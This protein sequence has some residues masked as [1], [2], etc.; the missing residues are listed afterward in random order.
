LLHPISQCDVERMTRNCI[1]ALVIGN[2]RQ[3]TDRD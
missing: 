1:K 2:G 3:R